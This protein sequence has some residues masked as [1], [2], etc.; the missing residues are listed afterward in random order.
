MLMTDEPFIAAILAAPEDNTLRLVYADWLDERGDPRGEFIRVQCALS[1]DVEDEDHRKALHKWQRELL[2]L[3][4]HA[5]LD[6]LLARLVADYDS[7]P[8]RVWERMFR[9]GF[10]E[11]LVLNY[12]SLVEHA[13]TLYRL[14]PIRQVEVRLSR[15]EQVDVKELVA[16]PQLRRLDSLTVSSGHCWLGN[17]DHEFGGGHVAIHL[18]LAGVRSLATSPHLADLRSLSLPNHGL[19]HTAAEALA[20]ATRLGNLVELDLRLNR[21]GTGA[22][23][24][25]TSPCLARLSSLCLNQNRVGLTALAASPGMSRLTRLSLQAEE[26]GSHHEDVVPW[27]K[28]G[29]AE[30]E[31]LAASPH[32]ANLTHLDLRYNA[33]G[34]RG[35][36]ALAASRYLGKLEY[37][38]LCDNVIRPEGALALI[39]SPWLSGLTEL[40]IRCN[41]IADRECESLRSRFR[42]RRLEVGL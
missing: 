14:H 17:P 9:C 7:T 1:R 33:I 16:L 41:G 40:N 35:A 20:A 26:G 13:E 34:V 19:D 32:V 42:G 3:H 18:G 11:T 24:L 2:H 15:P 4:G 25:I 23:A 27:D 12:E 8:T 10:V 6:P 37:L 30:A 5:W 28:I 29:N 39:D 36:K 21:I 31:A 22:L 38:D